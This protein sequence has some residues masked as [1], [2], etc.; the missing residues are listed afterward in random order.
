[1]IETIAQ[2]VVTV[3]DIAAVAEVLFRGIVGENKLYNDT[4]NLY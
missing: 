3:L 2:N 1:M 4:L